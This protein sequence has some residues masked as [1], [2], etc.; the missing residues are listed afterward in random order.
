MIVDMLDLLLLILFMPTSY[1]AHRIDIDTVESTHG[2]RSE[3]QL[4]G[5]LGKRKLT[6]L[7]LNSRLWGLQLFEQLFYPKGKEF[8]FSYVDNM[9]F[10]FTESCLDLSRP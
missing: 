9:E 6:L 3:V 4:V 1:F 5:E 7:W 10:L 2:V 8:L